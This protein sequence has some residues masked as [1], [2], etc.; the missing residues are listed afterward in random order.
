MDIFCKQIAFQTAYRYE[1]TIW[2]RSEASLSAL[3]QRLSTFRGVFDT[4]EAMKSDP[5]WPLRSHCSGRDHSREA[6]PQ[7]KEQVESAYN[8]LKLHFR[9]GRVFLS[10]TCHRVRRGERQSRRLSS[11]RA[12]QA[13]AREDYCC[14]QQLNHDS[15]H[16]CCCNHRPEKYLAPPLL[17]RFG[18]TQSARLWAQRRYHQGRTWT[19][20]ALRQS[21]RMIPVKVLKEQLGYQAE[22]YAGTSFWSPLSSSG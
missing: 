20:V 21:I 3:V 10:L 16:V 22:L 8:N 4:L 5:L 2:L 12:G 19:V 13:P 14:N 15:K 7:L 18:A 1:T 9:L 17:T 6:R 11:H